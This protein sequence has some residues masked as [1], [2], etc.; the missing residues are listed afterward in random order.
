M[1]QEAFYIN[2]DGS[3]DMNKSKWLPC[4]GGNQ[5][6]VEEPFT[7][8]PPPEPNWKPRFNFR[9]DKWTETA[10]DEEMAESVAELTEFE[11]LVQTV[12]DLEIK[13]LEKEVLIEQLG[14]Q[15]T[16]LEIQL[17]ESEGE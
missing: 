5:P 10:T 15:V 11:K 13:D 3:W 1:K 7:L 9:S 12:S 8:I 17:M 16:D 2:P 6:I 4:E 14:Q